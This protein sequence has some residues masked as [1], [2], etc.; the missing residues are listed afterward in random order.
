EALRDHVTTLD[1]A[2][3][4]DSAGRVNFNSDS[5]AELVRQQRVSAGFFHTLGVRPHIGREFIAEEDRP[6]GPPVVVLSHSFW[7]RVFHADASVA[8]RTILLRG[9]PY[10]VVG[11]M[12]ANFQSS[13]AADVWTPL[14]P[15]RRGEGAGINYAILARLR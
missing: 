3:F 10:S 12:P 13:V 5:S 6:G 2:A 11:I 4:K 1:V 7:N 8:G 15:S 9:E 14:R